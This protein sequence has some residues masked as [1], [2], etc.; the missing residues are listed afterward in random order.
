MAERPKQ[1]WHLE[2]G[3]MGSDCKIFCNGI[4]LMNV[5]KADLHLEA[6]AV[7]TL[8]LWYAS[9]GP[10]TKPFIENPEFHDGDTVTAH[11]MPMFNSIEIDGRHFRLLEVLSGEQDEEGLFGPRKVAQ[12][13][14]VVT[15]PRDK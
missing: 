10:L 1:E 15:E 4:Q 12:N 2:I 6:G 13:T 11:G 7:S 9:Y 5:Q 8:R 3:K 14:L